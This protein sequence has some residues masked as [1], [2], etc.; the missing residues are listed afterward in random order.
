MQTSYHEVIFMIR[1][2]LVMIQL[3][4]STVMTNGER[5]KIILNP[6]EDQIKIYGDWVE[7]EIQSSGIN[8]S[9]S[10]EWW[11]S[12]H[13]EQANKVDYCRAFKIACDLLNGDFLYGV[14]T[15]KIYKLMMQKDNVVS[16]SSYEEYILNHLQELDKGQYVNS[17]ESLS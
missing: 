4:E 12:E 16:G 9:C 1:S 13:K 3:K 5:I 8:F 7:V 10:L 6:R 17:S 2:L 15:D 14:D 11:N